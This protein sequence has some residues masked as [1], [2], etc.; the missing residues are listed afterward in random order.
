MAYCGG[1]GGRTVV[2]GQHCS[3]D[4]RGDSGKTED[5]QLSLPTRLRLLGL[6]LG[7]IFRVVVAGGQG[8]FVRVAAAQLQAE[9]D[10][11]ARPPQRAQHSLPA[12]ATAAVRL[13]PRQRRS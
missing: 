11:V 9:A 3:A 10:E 5:E 7:S 13:S 2:L 4:N 8:G 6:R 12:K 1:A